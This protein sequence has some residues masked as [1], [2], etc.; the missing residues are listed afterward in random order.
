MINSEFCVFVREV[1]MTI[2]MLAKDNGERLGKHYTI[3]LENNQ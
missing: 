1:P 3:A 2:Q